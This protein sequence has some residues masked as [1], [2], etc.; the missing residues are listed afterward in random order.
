LWKLRN[1][2]NQAAK[3]NNPPIGV[4][5]PK[6]LKLNGRKSF[7]AIKYNDPENSTIPDKVVK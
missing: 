2:Q 4:T 1:N 3:N 6:G 5:N 7:K